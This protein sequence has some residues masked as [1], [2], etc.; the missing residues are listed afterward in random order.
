M[1]W[2][3]WGVAERVS[4]WQKTEMTG[5][6]RHSFCCRIADRVLVLLH[7]RDGNTRHQCLHLLHHQDS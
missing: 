3:M 1:L 5:H 6:H 2:K 4:S 7:L